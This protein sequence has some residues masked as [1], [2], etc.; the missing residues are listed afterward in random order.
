MRYRRTLQVAQLGFA[1]CAHPTPQACKLTPAHTFTAIADTTPPGV[2][3]G[4]VTSLPDSVPVVGA[5][6]L[7]VGTS[8]LVLSNFLG[9]F[10]LIVPVADSVTLETRAINYRTIHFRLAVPP[11]HGLQVH[12]SLVPSCNQIIVVPASPKPPPNL[13]LKLSARWRRLCRNAQWK[14]SFWSAAPAARSLSA[15]R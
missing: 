5:Q 11:E 7:V 8:T 13:R 9:L 4:V 2:L 12:I 15:T 10:H 1:A 6:I 3:G 14:P